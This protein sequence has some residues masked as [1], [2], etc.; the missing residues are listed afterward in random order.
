M[1][2]KHPALSEWTWANVYRRP[3]LQLTA[4]VLKLRD[5]WYTFRGVPEDAHRIKFALKSYNRG[6]QGVTSE[7][8][9]C[10]LTSGCDPLKFTGNAGDLCTASRTP[11]YGGRSACDISLK[12]V[13]DIVNKR[14]PKYR[15]WLV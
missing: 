15:K 4:I 5:N 6:I 12:Y 8:R 13:P 1:K 11:I 3:D 2:E 7:M 9:V 14:A 10:K